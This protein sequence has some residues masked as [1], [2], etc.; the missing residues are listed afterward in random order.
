MDVRVC[1][2]RPQD[3]AAALALWEGSVRAT[4]HFV[5]GRHI[6]QYKEMV[7]QT[8]EQRPLDV[9][10]LYEGAGGADGAAE[11]EEQGG[12][13]LAIM[14]VEP[15]EAMLGMLFVA[16]GQRGLGYGR[17]MIR[18][19][20]EMGVRRVDVNE[21]NL[22]A[23][24]FYERMGFAARGVAPLDGVGNPYPLVH[25]ELVNPDCVHGAPDRN[26]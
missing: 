19:A 17:V 14:G 15:E 2:L 4:H 7:R 20:L 22:D 8:L 12:R 5:D 9:Y 24:V 21:Q 13:L 11:V 10:G 1:P 6:Q 23:R 3:N 25:M 16:D 18:H 26:I